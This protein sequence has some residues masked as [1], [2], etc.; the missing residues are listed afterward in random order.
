[1]LYTTSSSSSL[2]LRG[3]HCASLH[4]CCYLKLLHYF[5]SRAVKCDVHHNC[6]AVLL[7]SPQLCVF[8]L[9]SGCGDVAPSP[10]YRYTTL[11]SAINTVPRPCWSDPSSLLRQFRCNEYFTTHPWLAWYHLNLL[12]SVYG[13][14]MA[15]PWKTRDIRYKANFVTR[16]NAF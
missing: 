5:R 16:K 1:M 14:T 3:K 6:V 10:L 12:M 8:V 7:C 9:F 4:K 11:H 15:M 13:Q 2:L